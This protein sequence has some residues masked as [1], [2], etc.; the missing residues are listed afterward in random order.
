MR[1]LDR[2]STHAKT[3][4]N[5]TDVRMGR[6]VVHAGLNAAIVKQIAQTLM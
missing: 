3:T 4:S 1:S 6:A 5:G 2:L